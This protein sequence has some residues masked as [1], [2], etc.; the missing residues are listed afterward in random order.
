LLT[1]RSERPE[2]E[3]EIRHINDEAFGRDVEGKIIDKL[4]S[5]GTLTISLVALD[6]GRI[7]GYIAFSPAETVP[8][9]LTIRAIVL[10]PIAVLPDF[11]R[12]GIG[13]ELIESGLEKCRELGYDIVVLVGHPDYYPRFGFVPASR[14]GIEC[15]FEA[16]DEAWMLLELREG[17]LAGRR[18]KV[19]F[20]PA[21][22]EAI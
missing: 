18:G 22:R 15:E 1:V 19:F 12:K 2:D 9:N 7:A 6:D 13:W 3:A 17:A 11:Q 10:G 16:P 14:M 8:D 21:F 5:Q 20:Q 4:R